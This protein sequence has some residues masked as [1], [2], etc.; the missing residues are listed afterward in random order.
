MV[1]QLLSREV[2]LLLPRECL[3]LRGQLLL[4]LLR[5]GAVEVLERVGYLGRGRGVSAWF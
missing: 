1:P 4:V 3:T 2:R 5:P